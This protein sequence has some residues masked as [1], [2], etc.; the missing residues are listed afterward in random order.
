MS[1]S[2]GIKV[3]STVTDAFAKAVAE[4]DSVRA[5]LLLIEGGQYRGLP[6]CQANAA[7]RGVQPQADH[8]T[9]GELQG[10]YCSA[11]ALFADPYELCVLGLQDGH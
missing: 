2:S 7:R 5:L 6:A 8:C 1:A 10:G 4:P 3:S 11:A 9:Q